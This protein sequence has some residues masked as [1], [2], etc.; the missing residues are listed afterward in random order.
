MLLAALLLPILAQ[1]PATGGLDE[2]LTATQDRSP[3]AV[4]AASDA[5]EPPEGDAWQ[6]EAEALLA[7]AGPAGRLALGRLLAQ[8]DAIADEFGFSIRSFH[9]ALEAYKVRDLLIKKEISIL[10]RMGVKL[11]INKSDVIVLNS[12]NIKPVS[13]NT[14]PYPGFPTD[15]QA[16]IMVL[17]TRANGVSKIRE[18]IFEKRFMHVP[19]LNRMGA[20]I[21]IFGD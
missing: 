1:D 13:I 9:H 15:L 16:Q 5:Y 3:A 11:K 18:N 8:F 20:K 12:K 17:M 10:K 6:A 2:L 7:G 19:E 4:V 21:K 14:E